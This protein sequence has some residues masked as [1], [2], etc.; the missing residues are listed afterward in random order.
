MINTTFSK[1]GNDALD[2]SGSIVFI[3]EI[4]IKGVGDKGV[5]AGEKSYIYGDGIYITSSELGIVSKD[6]SLIK[7]D[8]ATLSKVSV[9]FAVFQKKSEFGSAQ[10]I[11]NN[12]SSKEFLEEFLIENGSKVSVNNRSLK[13]SH[14][15]VISI[16]YGEKYGKRSIR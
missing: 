12:Y 7:L 5:S 2:F 11:L 3:Q 6:L 13:P 14:K 10:L 8:N 4:D 9:P 15:D 1:I 16:L